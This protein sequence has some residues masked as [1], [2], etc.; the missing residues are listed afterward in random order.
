MTSFLGG[1]EDKTG[2]GKGESRGGGEEMHQFGGLE[3][4]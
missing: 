1:M 2:I 4:L 3:R